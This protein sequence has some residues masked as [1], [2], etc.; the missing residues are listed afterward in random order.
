MKLFALLILSFFSIDSFCQNTL[1]TIT[2]NIDDSSLNSLSFNRGWSPN[3]IN[4]K[5]KEIIN[6]QLDSNYQFPTL[7]NTQKELF[8]KLTDF[9]NYWF[10]ESSYYEFK[11]KLNYSLLIGESA[12]KMFINYYT[13]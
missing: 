4:E 1:C 12:K 6:N 5:I 3:E 13:L 2:K 7:E 11:E 8:I 10:F 9:K